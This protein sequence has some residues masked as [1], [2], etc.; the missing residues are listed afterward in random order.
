MRESAASKTA[1]FLQKILTK[2]GDGVINPP[3]D[4]N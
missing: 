2:V 1:K 4:N 3:R